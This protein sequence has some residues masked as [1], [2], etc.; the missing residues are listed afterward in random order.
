MTQS[1][2]T[3]CFFAPDSKEAAL[4]PQDSGN[5]LD[6]RICLLRTVQWA[7]SET[8]IDDHIAYLGG[9]V[10]VIYGRPFP[11]EKRFKG[12]LFTASELSL[13]KEGG[14]AKRQRH[15]TELF[16]RH[17]AA[18]HYDA[19]LAEYGTLGMRACAA[20]SQA[21]IPCV[22]HFHGHDASNKNTLKRHAEAYQKM[23]RQADRFIAVSQVMR[24]RLID[25]GAPP[26]RCFVNPCGVAIPDG[27]PGTPETSEPVFLAVGRFVKKKA[28]NLTLQAFA[29]ARRQAPDMRLVMTG[30][31]ELQEA[32]KVLAQEL[33]VGEAVS[34]PGVVSREVVAALMRTS[35]AFVQHSVTAA[36]G[37]SEGMPVAILEAGAAGLPVIATRHAGIPEAV[38]EREN[39]FLVEE[40]DVAGMA[41]AMLHLAKDPELA[42]RLGRNYRQ[43]VAA[44]FSREKSIQGLRNILLD[45]CKQGRSST[46]FTT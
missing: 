8:F 38:L 20:C 34:F 30:K 19:V 24:R 37:D 23:F 16:A 45:A 9:E 29:L 10:T 13:L 18:E 1:N 2:N 36:S 7:Y 44:H 15:Y 31:G 22:V 33:G 42:G 6:L 32:C 43:R 40:G 27:N 39:G 25:M 46:A 28:P 11:V 35:R 3:S 4:P 17:L 41:Q 12:P 5:G 14:L 26:Q 21:N